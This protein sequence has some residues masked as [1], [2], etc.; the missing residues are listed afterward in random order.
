MY[1]LTLHYINFKK[2]TLKKNISNVTHSHTFS[3]ITHEIMKM[4]E[5]GWSE[6]S[7][8]LCFLCSK[9]FNLYSL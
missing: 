5:G 6:D 9:H 3:Y 7:L 4:I 1:N 8:T 2:I